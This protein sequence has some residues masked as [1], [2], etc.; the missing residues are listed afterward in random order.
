MHQLKTEEPY[1]SDIVKQTQ[2]IAG[3]APNL[4]IRYYYS[5]V[6]NLITR[7][8][9]AGIRQNSNIKLPQRLNAVELKKAM[10]VGFVEGDGWFTVSKKGKYLMYEFGIE[11]NI[12]DV[13]LIYNL[14]EF[15]GVGTVTFR[16]TEGRSKTVIYRI[17]NKSHLKAVILPIFDNYPL[18]S[19][20]QYD[21]L[22]FRDALLKG[23]ILFDNLDSDYTRPTISLNSVDDILSV[24][25]FS[26]WLVGFIEA[27]GCFSIYLPSDSSSKVA[28]FDIAQ[29]N[30]SNLILAIAKY[31]SLT[32]KVHKDKTN[33]FKL[34]VSSVKS[35]ENVIKF[36]QKAPVKLIGHKNLQYLLWLK[37][38]RQIP[39]YTKKFSIPEIY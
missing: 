20:K 16:N 7:S 6:K 37:E 14:K 19:N 21:Y 18:L 4:S 35:V 24:P 38:L 12:R 31:L 3:M 13:Q 17:R 30:E 8:K 28:S 1:N 11:L 27:E 34:K 9:P 10:L 36:M 32:Q 15:L 39:R 33:S 23:I 29:T 2:L 22:R 5:L 25:Y 26:S